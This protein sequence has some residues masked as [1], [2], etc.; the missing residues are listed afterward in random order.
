MNKTFSL[1]TAIVFQTL[2]FCLSQNSSNGMTSDGTIVGRGQYNRPDCPK[3]IQK[4]IHV[5]Y[6]TRSPRAIA[7]GAK[8]DKSVSPNT[9]TSSSSLKVERLRAVKSKQRSRRPSFISRRF[10]RGRPKS[11]LRSR[12]L[13]RSLNRSKSR[14]RRGR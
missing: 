9:I 6:E 4:L 12:S 7:E 13:T 3:Q 11:R 1:Q 5:A 8:Q 10:S 2:K 14:S